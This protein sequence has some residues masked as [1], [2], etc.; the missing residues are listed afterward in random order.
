MACGHASCSAGV[1]CRGCRVVTCNTQLSVL[2]KT[3]WAP[4]NSWNFIQQSHSN[5]DLLFCRCRRCSY[6]SGIRFLQLCPVTQRSLNKA[7]VC[8]CWA[9][10]RE[11]IKLEE[12]AISEI[13]VTDTDL[14][15]GAKVSDVRRLI[16]GRRRRG[17]TA[18]S[19]SRSSHNK[20]WPEKSIQ[21]LCHLFS[22]RSQRK[23]TMHQMWC[24][25]V[26]CLVSREYYT[27]VN[28]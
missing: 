25:P 12:E 3:S 7:D 11:E 13:L 19:L 23:G 2:L 6:L 28:L 15:S 21:L 14:E 27:K 8:R 18:A 16:W 20:Q 10:A 4:L 5:L 1:N 9:K 17:K 26:W 22:S 24:G